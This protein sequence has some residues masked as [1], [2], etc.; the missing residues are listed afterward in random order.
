MVELSKLLDLLKLGNNEGPALCGTDGYVLT[1]AHI[2]SLFYTQLERVQSSHPS[3]MDQQINVQEKN[4][5]I[6]HCVEVLLLGLEM[7]ELVTTSLI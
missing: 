5:H 2:D 1:S 4:L 3:L 6:A 7:W